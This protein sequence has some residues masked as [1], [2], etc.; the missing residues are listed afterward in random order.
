MFINIKY[1]LYFLYI[2]IFL[3]IKINDFDLL[4]FSIFN[5]KYFYIY[6]FFMLVKMVIEIE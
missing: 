2:I 6:L 1:C 3:I 5:I 4:L